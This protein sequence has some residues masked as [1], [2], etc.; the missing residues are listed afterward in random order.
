MCGI[1]GVVSLDGTSIDE[2]ALERMDGQLGHRGPNGRGFYARPGIVLGHRRLSILDPSPAGAQPM[3]RGDLV[4]A[5]NGEVY[6]YLEIA[7]ELAPSGIR[8]ETGTDTEVILAAYATWGIDAIRRFNGMFAF[9]LWDGANRRLVLARDRLGVKPL[10]VRRSG[11][12]L[13]FASELPALIAAA[14]IHAGDGWHPEPNLAA[15][16]DFLVRGR[17]DHSSATFVEG[18]VALD[19][20]HA[21]VIEDGRERLIRYWPA[22]PLS[23][24]ARMAVRGEDLRRDERLLDE[25]RS[26]FDASV[27]LRLRSD[28]PI[29]SCLS[30]GLDSSSIVLTVA[31]LLAADPEIAHEQAPR[32]AFHAR[33]PDQGVDESRFAAVVARQAGMRMVQRTPRPLSVL[34]AVTTVLR[35]QGEPYDAASVHAQYAVMQAARDTGVTVLLDGQGA[36]E[37]LGGY[38]HYGG[39]LAGSLLRSGHP[40]AAARELRGQV[41]RGSYSPAGAILG[42][43][44]GLLPVRAIETARGASMGRLGVRVGAALAK[45]SSLESA[46]AE[47]GTRLA[48]HLWQSVTRDGLPALLRYEDRNSMAFG[49]ESRV[50]FLDYRLVELAMRLP[51]R[52]KIHH[53][54]NKVALRRTM[55]DRLP[56]EVA[57]RRDKMGFAAPQQAWLEA[58]LPGVSRAVADGQVV[59]RGWVARSDVEALVGALG[60]G[61]RPVEQL[62][63]LLVTELWLRLTWPQSASD[64][65]EPRAESAA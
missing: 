1:S 39:F 46:H 20:G 4:L 2:A 26:L 36:D 42:V 13:S 52:L 30:G 33:F 59:E 32:I 19:P 47:P 8:M 14:P 38:I 5:H 43:T 23:D 16:R 44:R 28:V 12:A 35:A 61:R 9:A 50:P 55:R 7:E 15:V 63:R 41:A 22:P 62:W 6:N 54:V 21:L 53:G 64:V 31:E 57:A 11:H 37:L 27:R 34:D 18:I 24:D 3:H 17:L 58:D 29:G 60:R 56:P 40:I 45:Q 25:F 48:R 49:L 65:G 51:D 10:Y